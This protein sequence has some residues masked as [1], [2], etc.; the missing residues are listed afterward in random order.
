VLCCSDTYSTTAFLSDKL[1]GIFDSVRD[2]QF[3]TLFMHAFRQC[4]PTLQELENVVLA[5]QTAKL[6][7]EKERVTVA[8]KE[9]PLVVR[10]AWAWQRSLGRA[11]RDGT[12]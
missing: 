7:K 3:A 8:A 10:R 5:E 4:E 6:D 1:K 2:E 11:R 9:V 12:R